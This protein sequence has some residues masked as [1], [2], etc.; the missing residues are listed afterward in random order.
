[1]RI[2]N[3]PNAK[4]I[5]ART[6]PCLI[7]FLSCGLGQIQGHVVAIALA[8]DEKEHLSTS[9]KLSNRLAKGNT[10]LDRVLVDLQDHIAW[11]NPLV[12]R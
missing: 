1:M 11:S 12:I 4:P 10:I 6:L 3:P 8:L 7:E 5:A 2:S 9:A